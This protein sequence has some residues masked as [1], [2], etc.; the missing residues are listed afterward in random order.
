MKFWSRPKS[1]D[2]SKVQMAE[3]GQLAVTSPYR[4]EYITAIDR[5]ER[6]GFEAPRGFWWEK[7]GWI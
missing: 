1:G 2:T 7:T 3:P 6:F 4:A 5:A